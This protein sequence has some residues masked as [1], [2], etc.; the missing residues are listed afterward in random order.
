MKK[1]LSMCLDAILLVTLFPVHA[2]AVEYSEDDDLIELAC[3][4]FPEYEAS[5]RGEIFPKNENSRSSNREVIISESRQVSENQTLYYTEYSDGVALVASSG[6]TPTETIIN[7][8]TG[9]SAT[10]ITSKLVVKCTWSNQEFICNNVKYVTV[11]SQPDYIISTGNL[12]DSDTNDA[13]VKENTK[14]KENS[15]GPARIDY[16]AQFQL[17]PQFNSTPLEPTIYFTVGQNVAT[18]YAY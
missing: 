9:A 14:Y 1:L 3:E 4:V 7:N 18:F 11:S 16:Y 8:D 10:T 6:F 15:S 17:L 2:L 12:S 13:Y 5:I